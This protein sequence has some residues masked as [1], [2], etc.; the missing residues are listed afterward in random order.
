MTIR[1]TRRLLDSQFARFC[2]VGASGYLVNLAVYAALL[3]AG[4]H[5]L[6]RAGLLGE[7]F[8][9]GLG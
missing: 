8:W 1:L 2:L 5:Y 4:L 9:T 7:A 3:A 6:A